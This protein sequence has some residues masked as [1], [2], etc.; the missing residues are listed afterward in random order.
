MYSFDRWQNTNR[1]FTGAAL[2]RLRN[3]VSCLRWV[4][5]SLFE[6]K[7]LFWKASRT[8]NRSR[9]LYLTYSNRYFKI[10]LWVWHVLFRAAS[11]S[12]YLVRYL[13]LCTLKQ[14][15][16]RFLVPRKWGQLMVFNTKQRLVKTYHRCDTTIEI[17][18]LHVL[19][20]TL[21]YYIVLR[22]NKW[23]RKLSLVAPSFA[24]P[25][26]RQARARAARDQPPP[27]DTLDP[28]QNPG[29][30]R[31]GAANLWEIH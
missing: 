30:K 13:P 15:W 16:R 19:Y 28:R 10:Q 3:I 24:T 22:I 21:Y 23:K 25:T 12:L 5:S 11:S 27:P 17:L 31:F 29:P 14:Y 6:M 18:P 26:P 2:D 1:E 7:S 4:T 20:H 8:E 9:L